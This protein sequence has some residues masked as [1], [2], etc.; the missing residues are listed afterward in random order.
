M[1]RHAQSFPSSKLPE[2][3]WPLST[4][5]DDQARRLASLLEPLRL[6]TLYSSP[7]V[8]CLQTIGPLA[9]RTGLD[10]TMEPEL[11]ERRIAHTVRTDFAELWQRSWND[12]SFAL[13][14]CESSHE[15]QER[16]VA[17]VYE[18]LAHVNGTVGVCAHGNVIGLLLNHLDTSFGLDRASQLRNPDIIALDY[19]NDTLTWDT[20]YKL[21]GMD[22]IATDAGDTP[23][24]W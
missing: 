1:V 17:A 12:F 20:A 2:A 10:I 18:L 21:D 11:R 22:H 3:E 19:R 8:R 7:Y 13:P 15:A 16:F 9:E 5:G 6:S 4:A 23:I 14:G 24:D